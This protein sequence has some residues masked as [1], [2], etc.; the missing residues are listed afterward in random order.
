MARQRSGSKVTRAVAAACVFVFPAVVLSAS[1]VSAAPDPV[2]GPDFNDDG[3][4]DI[5]IGVPGEDVGGNEDAGQ[6]NVIYGS[7][8]GLTSSG[9]QSWH[10][11]SPGVSGE[12]EGPRGD[13]PGDG[14]GVSVAYGNFNN[15]AFDDL[16]VG[17]PFEDI[18]SS[19][20]DA[21][22]V[23]IFLGSSTGLS[24]TGN[25]VW[26]QNVAGIPSAARSN[27]LFGF[28]VTSA[29]FSG[30][31]IDDLAIGAILDGGDQRGSVTVMKGSASGLVTSGIR[32]WTQDTPGIP[33]G[34]ESFDLFGFSLATGDLNA[35][36]GADLV[37]GAPGEAIGNRD[38]A[39]LVHV[40]YAGASGLTSTNSRSFSQENSAIAGVPEAGDGFG[41]SV[42]VG[43]FDA[44]GAE[45]VA[46]G[47]PGESVTKDSQGVIHTLYNTGTAI[48][49]N[50]SKF[51]HQDSPGIES[52]A[53]AGES[54]GLS[55]AAADFNSS[56]T[57]DIA[58]GAPGD[59]VSGVVS[60]SV[61]ILAATGD[62]S[63]SNGEYLR[64]NDPND[65]EAFGYALFVGDFDGVGIADLAIGVP[66][67]DLG[68]FGSSSGRF[69]GAVDIV[70]GS[71][72][73][74]SITETWHQDAPGILGGAETGDL[75][76]VFSGLP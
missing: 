25:E 49:G 48:S 11:D 28:T 19:I 69:G 18:G 31:G 71:V 54:F 33:G 61:N 68:A 46:V 35:T 21:G 67:D 41:V 55:L 51:L 37:I 5:A 42:A 72:S 50:G 4:A 39:G 14:F 2:A 3:F 27:E 20:V 63:F 38:S 29:D 74:F 76:G 24:A 32:S 44:V 1:S 6:V 66:L 17:T 59:S 22:A 56:G 58:V 65:G 70:P 16:A 36:G 7:A 57:D 43:R 13:S 34:A 52:A 15:D 10:Q 40:I 9:N 73:G 8:T 23:Q 12:P 75:F 60:G 53:K 30:D 45:D 47:V 64:Q 26:H 62:G